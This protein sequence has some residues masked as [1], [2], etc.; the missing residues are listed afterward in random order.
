MRKILFCLLALLV[1]HPQFSNAENLKIR[2][3]TSKSSSKIDRRLFSIISYDLV[4]QK[5]NKRALD[6]FLALNPN[7]TQA[8]MEANITNVEPENDNDDPFHLNWHGFKWD[9]MFG[10]KTNSKNFIKEI[11]DL[12]MEPVILFCYNAPWLGENG[13]VTAPPTNNDEWAEYV[14]AVLIY[15]NGRVTDPDMPPVVK[16]VEIWNEPSDHGLYWSG[17][18]KQYYDLFNIVAQRIHKEFPGV[19]VGGPSVLNGE[20]IF[21]KDFLTHCGDNVDFLSYH[22]YG[23]SVDSMKTQIESL[24]NYARD[25][26]GNKDLK[27]MITESDNISVPEDQKTAYLI[28]RQLALLELGEYLEGFH[29]FCAMAYCEGDRFFGLIYPDG[30]IV[31]KNY[32]PFWIFRNLEG[33]K[34]ETPPVANDKI[35]IVASRLDNEEKTNVVVYSSD[36]EESYAADLNIL[37][38]PSTINRIVCIE[39]LNHDTLETFGIFSL[40]SGKTETNVSL[41]LEPHT[42]YSITICKPTNFKAPIIETKIDKTKT[43]MGDTIPVNIRILNPFETAISGR[44]RFENLPSY[45]KLPMQKGATE[46]NN[47]LQ[48][49]TF[50]TRLMINANAPSS[51]KDGAAIYPTVYWKF[52]GWEQDKIS[53]PLPVQL[54]VESPVIFDARPNLIYAKSKQTLPITIGITN[55]SE[56]PLEGQLVLEPSFFSTTKKEELSRTFKIDKDS[57]MESTFNLELPQAI[58]EQEYTIISKIKLNDIEIPKEITLMIKE[59]EKREGLFPVNLASLYNADTLSFSKNPDDFSN[60]GGSYSFP[61]D[62]FPEAGLK[63]FLGVKFHIP[64]NIDGLKN[65]VRVN[66]QNIAFPPDRYNELHLIA[67][68]TNGSKV[69]KGTLVFDDQTTAP[70]SIKISDWC[71]EPGFG[72]LPLIKASHRHSFGGDLYDA[73]PSIFYQIIPIETEK[74]ITNLILPSETD[75][76]IYALT[77]RAGS[78]SPSEEKPNEAI[79]KLETE[80]FP[81]PS[82]QTVYKADFSPDD[83]EEN[84]VKIGSI[85]PFN[86]IEAKDDALCLE[87]GIGDEWFGAVYKNPLDLSK[88]PLSFKIQYTHNAKNPW[89]ELGFWYVKNLYKD[90][91]PWNR[92]DFIRVKFCNQG[93][94]ELPFPDVLTIQR[95]FASGIG[96]E[97]GKIAGLELNKEHELQITL[98][99][100]RFFIKIDDKNTVSGNHRMGFT[101]GYFYITD[102]NSYKGD[103]DLIQGLEIL[104]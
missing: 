35:H 73:T 55:Q 39:K 1:S 80:V 11:R 60:F 77:L 13:R 16:Y 36:K 86:R 99:Q 65:A 64:G 40:A 71:S 93:N 49:Y 74:T 21:L 104:Q 82:G 52:P 34:I 66:G 46:F 17:S 84:W 79:E 97:L 42:A 56:S 23:K 85:E 95:D 22:I 18:R 9:E 81:E 26:A 100:S 50:Q 94:P 14:S 5:G 59:Y 67:T 15:F 44:L 96:K 6:A 83:W 54:F 19:K 78:Y 57:H 43:F 47:L 30:G 53:H 38:N 102:T 62:F 8:R 63:E 87:G 88:G 68:A 89:N 33:E 72:E 103:I 98:T 3:D 91:N 58:L 20:T 2:V 24:V 101:K 28:E 27:M 12:G 45:W 75:L 92:E 51:M 70:V 10:L 31:P 7:G 25:A 90:E 32:Q 41:N 37:V 69:A 76:Y 48:G 61:A 4:K 29:H